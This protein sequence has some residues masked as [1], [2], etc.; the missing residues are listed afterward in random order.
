MLHIVLLILKIIGILLLSILG[1]LLLS[2]VCILFV[3]VRYQIELNREMGEGKPPLEVKTKVTWLL[4]L[5]N[6]LITYPAEVYVRVRILCFTVFRVPQKEKKKN[7]K[8]NKQNKK[9]NKQNKQ[10]TGLS[11]AAPPDQNEK[12]AEEQTKTLGQKTARQAEYTEETE[13]AEKPENAKDTDEKKDTS[14]KEDAA[15]PDKKLSLKERFQKILDKIK[16][17][18]RKIKEFFQNIQ[19]TIEH[20]CDKIKFVSEQIEYYKE[21]VTS[22]VFRQSF[23]LCKGELISIFMSLKP[24]KFEADLI[25][26]MD[27]PATTAQILAFWGMLYPVIGQHVNVA[28]DFEQTR[29]EGHVFLKGRI[30]A[31][32][33]IKA[34]IRIYFNKDIRKLIHLLKKEAV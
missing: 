7:K 26:G 12:S 33:F 2:I 18:F 34:A 13:S 5:L 22:D 3:P 8:D 10:E 21:I 4:H 28:G 31:I 27:D 14:A 23:Q 24:Q 17:I 11:S 19:Y 16:N 15:D 30:R 6:I 32:T 1:I 25:V 29:I 9:N 20:F